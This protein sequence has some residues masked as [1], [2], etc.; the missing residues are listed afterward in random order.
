MPAPFAARSK[1]APNL[2][3][4]SRMMS[5]GRR[6]EP[7]LQA[8][9][10][11]EIFNDRVAEER[12]SHDNTAQGLFFAAQSSC[13]AQLSLSAHPVSPEAARQQVFRVAAKV[14]D[15]AAVRSAWSLPGSLDAAEQHLATEH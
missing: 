7:Q 3:S 6:D 8:L 1:S 2:P 5:S 9:V 10:T 15:E 4:L 12:S 14:A 11:L 13:D